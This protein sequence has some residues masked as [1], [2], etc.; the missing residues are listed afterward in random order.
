MTSQQRLQKLFQLWTL[1]KADLFQTLQSVSHDC[2]K[3]RRTLPGP[4]SVKI[5]FDMSLGT[6]NADLTELTNCQY[7]VSV[8]L[9]TQVLDVTAK[10]ER[11]CVFSYELNTHWVCVQL[12]PTLSQSHRLQSTKSP[13]STEFSRQEYWSGLPFPPPRDV[14]KPGTELASLAHRSSRFHLATSC[15]L[16]N[17]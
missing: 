17:I 9:W 7:F 1:I 16:C 11:M 6:N 5:Y 15:A 13:L 2:V 10:A 4:E 12:C 3:G 14:P 8:I